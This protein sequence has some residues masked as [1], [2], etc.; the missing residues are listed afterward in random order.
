M[1][2]AHANADVRR[3]NT[4]S[5][6]I[7]LGQIFSFALGIISIGAGVFLATRGA[8]KEA[9]ASVIGGFAPVVIAAL[10]NFKKNKQ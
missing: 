5:A 1:A 4:E 9:I 8:T 10:S 2:E 7:V 6:S 3:K